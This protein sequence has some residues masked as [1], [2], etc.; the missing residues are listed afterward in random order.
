MII[1][2]ISFFLASRSDIIENQKYNDIYDKRGN[3]ANNG[4]L[5][6]YAM[7]IVAKMKIIIKNIIKNQH[8]YMTIPSLLP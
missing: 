1:K 8:M 4:S 7:S 2:I 6:S 5:I 3:N